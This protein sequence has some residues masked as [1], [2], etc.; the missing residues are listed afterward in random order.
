MIMV[1]VKIKNYLDYQ[2]ISDRLYVVVTGLIWL[3]Y[4]RGRTENT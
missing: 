2:I 3:L 1:Y 4:Q